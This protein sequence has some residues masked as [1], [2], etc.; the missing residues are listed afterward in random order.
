MTGEIANACAWR[1]ANEASSI[2]GAVIE[3]SG[4]VAL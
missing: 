3:V 1:A 2:T 4:G